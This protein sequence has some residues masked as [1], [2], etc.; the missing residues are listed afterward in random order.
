MIEIF[1]E[2]LTIINYGGYINRLF[3]EILP[4]PPYNRAIYMT[5]SI[6]MAIYIEARCL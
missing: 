2:I 3:S 4:L 6:N 5:H 1:D